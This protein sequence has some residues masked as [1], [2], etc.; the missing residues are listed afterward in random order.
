V[1]ILGRCN[2]ISATRTSSTRFDTIQRTFSRAVPR[3]S[4]RTRQCGRIHSSPIRVL[5]SYGDSPNGEVSMRSLGGDEPSNTQMS[6]T[7]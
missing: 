2:T 5:H 1:W 7:L 4:G 3:F 6:A